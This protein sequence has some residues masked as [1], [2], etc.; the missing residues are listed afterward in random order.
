MSR[1]SIYQQ[2]SKDSK[3]IKELEKVKIMGY[4]LSNNMNAENVV[5]ALDMALKERITD[6]NLFIILR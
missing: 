3:R 1:Q 6:K 2:E 5:E 4:K